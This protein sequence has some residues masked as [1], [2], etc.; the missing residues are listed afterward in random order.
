M[1]CEPLSSREVAAI[2]GL[3][4]NGVRDR[5]RRGLL[6]AE[7]VGGRW[8]FNAADVVAACAKE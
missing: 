6:R 2:L 3:T 1:E 5:R 4:A 8:K 7:R